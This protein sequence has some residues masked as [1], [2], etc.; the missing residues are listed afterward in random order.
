MRKKIEMQLAWSNHEKGKKLSAGE[1]RKVP[2]TQTKTTFHYGEKDA[3]SVAIVDREGGNG[4]V[5]IS[6]RPGE[7]TGAWRALLTI[8]TM[9]HAEKRS[10]RGGPYSPRQGSE[11]T[12]DLDLIA[13][14]CSITRNGSTKEEGNLLQGEKARRCS[15]RKPLRF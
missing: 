8:K 4:V 14:K 11:R 15:L 5:S 9:T 7:I 3:A 2:P 13:E 12:F 1:A 6:S 10:D